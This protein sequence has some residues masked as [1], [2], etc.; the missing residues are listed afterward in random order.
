MKK[1]LCLSAIAVTIFV[2]C[3]CGT[4]LSNRDNRE[5]PVSSRVYIY[6]GVRLETPFLGHNAEW[7]LPWWWQALIILDVP[8][9]SVADTICL[10]YTICATLR[11]P[12][13]I[14]V[15]FGRRNG[16][17]EAS[18]T[19]DLFVWI[20]GDR[21]NEKRPK[22]ALDEACTVIGQIQGGPAS[23]EAVVTCENSAT[24]LST[25]QY[26]CIADCI[27]SN[28]TLIFT[29]DF[30]CADIHAGYLRSKMKGQ[31]QRTP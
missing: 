8:L 31:S 28:K 19:G 2:T 14:T 11:Q 4:I 5:R 1:P 30:S 25:D 18:F 7:T 17:G 10:P 6:S 21:E 15:S 3:G 23:A 27:A 9:S 24:N 22:I 26:G 16:Y 20:D 13:F 12:R 29:P